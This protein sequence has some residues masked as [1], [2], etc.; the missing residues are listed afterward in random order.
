MTVLALSLPVL[1]AA[2]CVSPQQRAA[3]GQKAAAGA[4]TGRISVKGNEPHAYLA[5]T[6]DDGRVY[7]LTGGVAAAIR[8]TFQNRRLRVEGTIAAQAG[9]P[10]F[11]ARIEVT[12]F[13]EVP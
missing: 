13:L 3:D 5:L 1:A 9:G 6:T 7:E 12:G 2:G 8:N 11:P 10:G 4:W